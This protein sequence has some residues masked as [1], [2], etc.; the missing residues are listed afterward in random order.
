MDATVGTATRHI[1]E[2]GKG[3]HITLWIVQVLLALAFGMA[4]FMKLTT[5]SPS[6]AR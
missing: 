6:L 4:G 1:P 3:L 2:G 5:P